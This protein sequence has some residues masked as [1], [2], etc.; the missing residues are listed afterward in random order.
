M[1]DIEQSIR[2]AWEEVRARGY[3]ED[4]L[5]VV[6]DVFGRLLLAERHRA[7]GTKAPKGDVSQLVDMLN[8]FHR[9]GL[10]E[11]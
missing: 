5:D 4:V 2:T 11:E 7:V 8:E 3:K 10:E 1:Q 9:L 6:I